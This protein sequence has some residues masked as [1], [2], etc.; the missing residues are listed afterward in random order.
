ML[1]LLD[2]NGELFF[3]IF[4]GLEFEKESSDLLFEGEMLTREMPRF[5][6]FGLETDI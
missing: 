6:N 1:I 3:G 4:E 2:H 5:L